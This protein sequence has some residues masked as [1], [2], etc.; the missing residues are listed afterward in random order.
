[1]YLIALDQHSAQAAFTAVNC[2]IE[3][4]KT[5]YIL[6]LIVLFFYLCGKAVCAQ[7]HDMFAPF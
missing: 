1:M 4:V 7:E 2:Y 5:M 3:S 6:I